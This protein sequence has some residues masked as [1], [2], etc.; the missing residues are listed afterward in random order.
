[1]TEVQVQVVYDCAK[2]NLQNR[3][4][5][6]R[7]IRVVSKKDGPMICTIE[8]GQIIEYPETPQSLIEIART[9]K[10]TELL[11]ILDQIRDEV[12][13][14]RVVDNTIILV[15]R[16]Q[17]GGT[18]NTMAAS[19]DDVH[20]IGYNLMLHPHPGECL[21]YITY[22]SD[23]G[24]KLEELELF[25]TLCNAKVYYSHRLYLEGY[26]PY[27]TQ[28]NV[29]PIDRSFL[30]TAKV[31][32]KKASRPS[33]KTMCTF[34]YH[35]A[36]KFYF[37]DDETGE[38]HCFGRYEI[39]EIIRLMDKGKVCVEK[40]YEIS[41]EYQSFKPIYSGGSNLSNVQFGGIINAE[42]CS[43]SDS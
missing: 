26:L 32:V 16:S 22:C 9:P 23:P 34:K 13:R 38:V 10:S 21:D 11:K 7:D 6:P 30:K 2:K 42:V 29:F 15:T 3:G 31:Y 40:Q 39:D 43:D 27:T 36:N 14:Y 4:T 19:C 12:V 35:K 33:R 8:A 24:I 37:A 1:M 28:N 20:I 25:Y 17:S 18:W 41:D 5:T